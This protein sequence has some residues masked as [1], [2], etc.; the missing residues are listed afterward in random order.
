MTALMAAVTCIVTMV[1][2]IP[3][4]LRGYLNLG[5]AAVLLAGWLL[6][7]MYGFLGA[8]I[9]SAMADLFSGYV[10]YA[11]AT[12]VIKGIMAL[13]A[14]V[15]CSLIGRKLPRVIAAVISAV[16]AEAV[17]IGGYFLFEGILYGIGA[18]AVNLIPN[19]V[20]GTVGALIGCVLINIL[21]E[22]KR[23]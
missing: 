4:P 23:I 12:F 11:P 7:P 19:T 2:Q 3:S 10:I 5:D 18:S 16:V 13:A 17:M 1:V 14:S 20:Q 21:P 9:G 8:G 22:K 15:L 6:S